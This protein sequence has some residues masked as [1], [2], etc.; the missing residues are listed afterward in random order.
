M[1]I[2]DEIHHLLAGSATRQR[3]FLNVL[4]YLGN[5]LKIPI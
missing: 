1:L 5:E 3:Q 4:K 2:V